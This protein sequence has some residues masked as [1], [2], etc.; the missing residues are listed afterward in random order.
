MSIFFCFLLE[1]DNEHKTTSKLSQDKEIQGLLTAVAFTP[2]SPDLK[3]NEHSR[4]HLKTVKAK[5]G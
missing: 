2:Q 1:Q 4:G 5:H 3:P